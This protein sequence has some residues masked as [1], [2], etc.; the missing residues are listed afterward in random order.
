MRATGGT[1]CQDCFGTVYTGIVLRFSEQAVFRQSG[2]NSSWRKGKESREQDGCRNLAW[3]DASDRMGTSDGI[4]I[5]RTC[6]RMPSNG[7]WKLDAVKAVTEFPRSSELATF[8]AGHVMTPSPTVTKGCN[9]PSKGGTRRTGSIQ[10][11]EKRESREQDGCRNLA[12][13]DVFDRRALHANVR[14]HL[15][16]TDLQAM[17]SDGRWKLDAV[18]TVTGVPWNMGAGRLVGRPRYARVQVLPSLPDAPT[19]SQ[20]QEPGEPVAVPPVP[21]PAPPPPAPSNPVSKGMQNARR[22]C[23]WETWTLQCLCGRCRS[24][25]WIS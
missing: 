16:C 14:W 3:Q 22:R 20:P 24:R 18:K 21:P 6:R 19:H 12:W 10:T 8:L 5:A 11:V 17:P 2:G 25:G 4:F 7:R 9:T 13:Q 23:L 15:H 1:S